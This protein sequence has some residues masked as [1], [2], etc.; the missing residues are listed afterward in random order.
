[1]G[2]YDE[3]VALVRSSKNGYI[4]VRT[5]CSGCRM[6]LGYTKEIYIAGKP[7][8][9]VLKWDST[10]YCGELSGVKLSTYDLAGY[11][12]IIKIT[13]DLI[14]TVRKGY[15]CSKCYEEPDTHTSYSIKKYFKKQKR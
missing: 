2:H 9:D 5:Q 1:M 3:L 14:T 12:R 11:H 15:T 6:P 7:L 4:F 13:P 8:E 10:Q